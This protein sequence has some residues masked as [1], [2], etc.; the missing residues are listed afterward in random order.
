MT[1]Y[2]S[3][4][5][6][7]E[8]LPARLMVAAGAAASVGL[9]FLATMR[10]GMYESALQMLGV[11]ILGGIAAYPIVERPVL[12]L[13]L[14]VP[15]A[16][17]P[18]L[19]FGGK[20]GSSVAFLAAPALV[21]LWLLSRLSHEGGLKLLR[22]SVFRPLAWFTLA[23]VV[24]FGV[25]Q[26]RWFGVAGAS[27]DARIAGLAMLMLSPA[28]LVMAAHEFRNTRWLKRA[29][30][31]L[32]FVGAALLIS[33]GLG[34][35]GFKAVGLLHTKGGM[36]SMFW[37]WLMAMS[38]SQ[39]VI[40]NKLSA[41]ARLFCLAITVG[42]LALTMGSWLEWASGWAPGCVALGVTLFAYRPR[43]A[44]VL[45]ILGGLALLAN[46]TVARDLAYTPDQA[47]STHTRAAAAQ[48][49]L[50]IA[51]QNPIT[52][53]GPANYYHYT[54]LFPI[55]GW[56]V[57]FNSHNNYFDLVLQTGLFGLFC[58]GWLWFELGRTYWRARNQPRSSFEKAFL[59]GAIG[60]VAGTAVGGA[61]GDWFLPFVYNVGIFGFGSSILAWIFMG[62]LVGVASL[63]DRQ[64]IP[65]V[66]L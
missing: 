12:G 5:F 47:Y 15:A 56:Y 22:S 43:F 9:L 61:L 26:Y 29:V 60:G 27:L 44:L 6:E 20:G 1:R 40:N 21:G 11:L 25:G 51:K 59:C 2:L 39:G 42:T 8:G 14:L 54:P 19:Q 28:I 7:L 66:D 50:E 38:F 64:P 17:L 35:L 52:G 33:S 10:Q 23:S 58:I 34:M 32:L 57:H 3:R 65:S 41:S 31:A 24:A 63:Q 13:L 36:G 49:L 4:L 55:L 37:T 46:A 45:G 30:W 16:I 62:A 18:P 53:F 48:T